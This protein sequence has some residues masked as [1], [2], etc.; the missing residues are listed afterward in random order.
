MSFGMHGW[1]EVGFALSSDGNG[2]CKLE[3][4]LVIAVKKKWLCLTE[5]EASVFFTDMREI[6]VFKGTDGWTWYGESPHK[7]IGGLF[8]ITHSECSDSIFITF[9]KE[10]DEDRIEMTIEDAISLLRMEKIIDGKFFHIRY[11]EKDTAGEIE[12][13]ASKY[14]EDA[15]LIKKEAESQFINDVVR[16]LATSHFPFFF[17]FVDEVKNAPSL[18]D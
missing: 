11:D 14:S 4:S 17:D 18:F 8:E 7:N 15:Y 5:A 2:E 6:N 12:E 10:G 9:K 3:I 13:L 1:V 16:Q